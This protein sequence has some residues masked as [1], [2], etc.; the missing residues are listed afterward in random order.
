MVVDICMDFK[1]FQNRSGLNVHFFFQ[2]WDCVQSMPVSWNRTMEWDEICKRKALRMRCGKRC[3]NLNF[4]SFSSYNRCMHD[5]GIV[6]SFFFGGG[7]K[8]IVTHLFSCSLKLKRQSDPIEIL[9]WLFAS[10]NFTAFGYNN[11]TSHT[12]AFEDILKLDTVIWISRC[13]Y[14]YN[15][16]LYRFGLS[17][18]DRQLKRLIWSILLYIQ[19]NTHKQAK[20][21]TENHFASDEHLHWLFGQMPQIKQMY[22]N[23]YCLCA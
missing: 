21:S 6:I 12:F 16:R 13:I 20:Y 2:I 8:S 3:M 10:Q 17:E 22:L 1:H 18:M 11:I 23:Y 9:A 7:E 14:A 15:F 4:E 19:T 5:I